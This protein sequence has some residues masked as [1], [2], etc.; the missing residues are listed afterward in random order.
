[1]YVAMDPNH[2]G[3]GETIEA[4]KAA[5]KDAGGRLTRYVVYAMPEGVIPDSVQVDG[6]G[7]INW[8]WADEN[9]EPAVVD[10]E[11]VAKRGV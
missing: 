4:A 5:M 6:M 8:R 2:W 10:L 3:R 11:V 7:R 9:R 1:M